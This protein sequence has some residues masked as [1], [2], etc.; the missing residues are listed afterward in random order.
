MIKNIEIHN[1]HNLTIENAQVTIHP[2]NQ[3][4][5]EKKDTLSVVFVRDPYAYFDYLMFDYLEHKRSL[6]FTQD[7][8]NHM[9]EFSSKNFLHWFDTLNFIPF[10][11]PQTFQ[12]DSA[13]RLESAIDNLRSFDYVVP[14]DEIDSFLEKFSSELWISTENHKKL[15]FSLEAQKNHT[16]TD[17]LISKDLELY[18]ESI[19]LW[20]LVKKNNFKPLRS[21]IERKKPIDNA[22][23]Q[24]D[25]DLLQQYK[26]LAGKITSNS[27][28]GWIF[29]KVK[30]ETIIVS[31]FKNNDFVCIAKAN[32]MREDLK[33]Q[34]IHPT[35]E[36]GFEVIFDLEMFKRGDKVEVKILPHN[37]PLPLGI[38]SKNFLGY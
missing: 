7:I 30:G 12:L 27:I 19:K 2:L 32:K 4:K 38:D 35:G 1:F 33:R 16:L 28:R 37:T 36:C 20:N 11:N 6:L 9:K 34:H 10:Y 29:H 26:G 31:I 3:P 18:D 22:V 25:S 13:K 5:E 14:Y 8:I 15:L 24:Q 17:K 21:L 23:S